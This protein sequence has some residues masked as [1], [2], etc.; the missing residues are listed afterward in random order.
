MSL[1]LTELTGVGPRGAEILAEHGFRS[2]KAIAAANVEAL[3]QVPGFSEARAQKCINQAK[4]LLANDTITATEI[5]STAS[6]IISMP[7]T[8]KKDKP[9]KT[10]KDKEKKSK[11]KKR[12]QKDKTTKDKKKDKKKRKNKNKQK[13]KNKGKKGKGKK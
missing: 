8:G 1:E 6:E 3:S 2:L 4:T 10:K 13:N 12:K 5:E 11:D 9:E 7:F